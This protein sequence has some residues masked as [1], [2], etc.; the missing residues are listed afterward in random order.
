M[1]TKFLKKE[2]E[3]RAQFLADKREAEEQAEASAFGKGFFAPIHNKRLA[4]IC[5]PQ[6]SQS[7]SQSQSTSQPNLDQY[8]KVKK[9]PLQSDAQLEFDT[10]LTLSLVLSNLP[11]NIVET[12][13]FKMLLNYVMP[14]A[15]I[16]TPQTLSKSKL[17]MLYNNLKKEVKKQLAKDVPDLSLVSVNFFLILNSYND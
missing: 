3:E 5:S 6:Q 2:A 4:N 10:V 14:K 8:V 1:F 7:Q 15:T 13:G 9:W 12:P 11:F 16:K 17:P